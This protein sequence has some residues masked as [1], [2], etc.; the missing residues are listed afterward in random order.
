MPIPSQAKSPARSVKRQVAV[1]VQ[2]EGAREVVVTGDFTGWAPDRQ[3]LDEIRRGEWSTLLELAP[4]EYQYRLLIDGEWRDDPQARQRVPNA[5]G[6]ENCI[7][8]VP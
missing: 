3:R 6:S 5:F 1:T 8:V 4:G 7:L 2:A